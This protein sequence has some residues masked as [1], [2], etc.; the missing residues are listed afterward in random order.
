V[1]R[2]NKAGGSPGVKGTIRF[3]LVATPDHPV[4][5]SDDLQTVMSYA[6]DPAI[7]LIT[8][9]TGDE[10]LV[11]ATPYVADGRVP[12]ARVGDCH[13]FLQANPTVYADLRARVLEALM[14]RGAVLT[15]VG[16]ESAAPADAAA[17][18]AENFA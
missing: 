15:A 14:A 16:G 5:D 2:K 11:L 12:F 3:W 1:V 10:K 7:G 8:E 17:T 4:G 9:G 13:T 6:R 18:E